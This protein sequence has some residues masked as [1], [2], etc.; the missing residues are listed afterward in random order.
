MRRTHQAARAGLGF[1]RDTRGATMTEYALILVVVAVVCAI[2]FKVFGQTL[3]SGMGQAGGHL[4]QSSSQSEP[5]A[6]QAGGA[7]SAAPVAETRGASQADPGSSFG[8]PR[9]ATV[10]QTGGSSSLSKF[11]MIALGVIGAAA[12]FFAIMK[13]KH[14][15]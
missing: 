8:G 5:P 12:A 13:G 15:R 11:A 9:Q 4:D 1:R 14:A 6:A 10:A 3:S 7:S 2:G